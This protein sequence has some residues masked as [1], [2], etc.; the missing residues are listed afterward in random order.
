MQDVEF[1]YECRKMNEHEHAKDLSWDGWSTGTFGL[2]MQ[3]PWARWILEGKKSIETRLYNF[4]PALIGQK[5]FILESQTGS[6]YSTIQNI[7]RMD[8][9]KVYTMECIGWCIFHRITLYTDRSQFEMDHNK[10][11]V[12][13]DSIFGWKDHEEKIIYGWEVHSYGYLNNEIK[14][15]VA[16]RRMRSL[17]QLQTSEESSS[18]AIP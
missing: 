8:D 14:W 18:I 9:P 1:C 10:H 15:N 2:E 3:K 16:I 13:R 17:F 7:T 11:C 6:G 12:D 4:P 5:I